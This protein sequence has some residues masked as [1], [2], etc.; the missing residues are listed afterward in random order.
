MSNNSQNI[1]TLSN[2]LELPFSSTESSEKI[3]PIY[4]VKCDAEE[5]FMAPAMAPPCPF[6]PDGGKVV[7][8]VKWSD[9]GKLL[10][11]GKTACIPLKSVG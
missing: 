3:H 8:L 5:D 9:E 11:G 7:T 10:R 2:Q 6:C 4:K 1:R